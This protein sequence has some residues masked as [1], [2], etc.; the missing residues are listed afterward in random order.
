LSEERYQAKVIVADEDEE[1]KV[2]IE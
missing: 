1:E 2:G